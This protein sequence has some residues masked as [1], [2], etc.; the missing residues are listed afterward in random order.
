MLAAQ[1]GRTTS[2]DLQS[3]LGNQ[4]QHKDRSCHV[5]RQKAYK[6][7]VQG[8]EGVS[9]KLPAATLEGVGQ[10]V[11]LGLTSRIGTVF[12][13]SRHYHLDRR[14]RFL[15][16]GRIKQK[17]ALYSAVFIICFLRR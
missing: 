11:Q 8:V 9:R 2:I 14:R 5:R 13:R 1:P 7:P 15:A 10:L 12:Y 17:T 16:P 3:Y 4:Y 6:R